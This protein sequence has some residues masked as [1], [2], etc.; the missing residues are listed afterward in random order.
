MEYKRYLTLAAI[1]LFLNVLL[2]Y[3]N[4]FEN[5]FHFD[6]SHT[7]IN[8]SFIRDISDFSKIK[9]FFTNAETF[10][11]KP[12]NQEY[13]PLITLSLAIDYWLSGGLKPFFFHVT[14]FLAFLLHLPLMFYF[15]RHIF[16][17]A[18]FENT[19]IADI[20][21][22]FS[23]WIFA[24]HPV[25]AETVNYII[26][27][28]DIFSTL[29]VLAAIDVYIFF[30]AKRKFFPDLLLI[31]IGALFKASALV[32]PLILFFYVLI[33]ESTSENSQTEKAEKGDE[34]ES[35]ENGYEIKKGERAKKRERFEN[36]YE[37][38]KDDEIRRDGKVEEVGNPEKNQFPGRI[39][40]AVIS[41]LPSLIIS[42]LLFI[43]I[44]SM[45]SKTSVSSTSPT[46][47]YLI[48]Q[49]MV[50][51]HYFRSFFAPLWLSADTDW[52]LINSPGDIRVF[53]GFFF[54]ISLAGAGY[55][56]LRNR[57]LSP[58]SFGI[59][60]FF[61]ALLP[62]SSII[63]LAEVLNDHRM[64][65]PYVG[66]SAC[67]IWGIFA[68][69]HNAG[70]RLRYTCF[71]LLCCISILS[72]ATHVRNR[73]WIDGDTLWKDVTEK[74]PGNGR[75]WMNYGVSLMSRGNYGEAEKCFM[76]ALTTLST[77][78]VL[79]VNLGVLKSAIK[80][81]KSA[82]FYFK[83]ALEL[84]PCSPDSYSFYAG[85]LHKTGRQKEA[86]EMIEKALS[87]SPGDTYSQSIKALINTPA[88]TNFDF[89]N[90][91]KHTMLEMIQ[92]GNNELLEKVKT[93]LIEKPDSEITLTL[94][95]EY[96][97]QGKFRECIEI[98]SEA[99]KIFPDSAEIHNNI[100]AAY[101]SLR[102]FEKAVIYGQKAVSLK[103]DFQLAI[104]NL[105]WAQSELKKLAGK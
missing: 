38:R 6:D 44:Q 45:R 27:R 68:V 76:H 19:L 21:A 79:H 55:F 93:K 99:L 54:V 53:L 67:I 72:I 82:E 69:A 1:V 5:G 97:K 103:P 28:S 37:I 88:K 78:S 22:L 105:A 52:G 57:K 102:E 35:N 41:S 12:T 32:Y 2:V 87:I 90:M 89:T 42:A 18:Q 83:K 36:G 15:F 56:F 71:L 49:P 91:N 58:V 64:F 24:V 75:G 14:N 23:V 25:N 73:V 46:L 85:F 17:K 51:A 63:A 92:T 47:L 100:C 62:T 16:Q 4:H 101:N 96:Y 33:F 95:L 60:W 86:S 34:I 50:I 65:F 8:N 74:S 43:F 61:I 10:S 59:F 7:I 66:L 30:P 3:S 13:R 80:D 84:N 9:K 29:F 20:A 70:I 98:A 77:Y 11:S 104:N 31:A 40:K 94:S 26:S 48:T 39:K 81:N